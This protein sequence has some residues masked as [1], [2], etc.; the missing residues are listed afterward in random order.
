MS[1]VNLTSLPPRIIRSKLPGLLGQPIHLETHWR[2]SAFTSGLFLEPLR[3]LALFEECF[4][5]GAPKLEVFCKLATFGRKS[6]D[7]LSDLGGFDQRWCM[8]GLDPSVDDQRA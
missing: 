5:P 4:A 3:A 7:F 1:L 6:I 8:M 2:S